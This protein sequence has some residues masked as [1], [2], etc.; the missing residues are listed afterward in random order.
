MYYAV[1]DIETRIDKS[2]VRQIYEDDDS[3]SEEEAYQKT[4][5]RL[6]E[7]NKG[8]TVFF[9]VPFHIPV[10]IVVGQI[11]DALELTNIFVL[12]ED[13]G[14]FSPMR[15]VSLFWDRMERFQGTLVSFN[16]RGFDLP[17][18]ELQA[19]KYGISAPRYFDTTSG[20]RY[21]FSDAGHFDLLD[22][23]TNYSAFFIK[24]GLNIL[25]KM[26]GLPGK[27]EI[28]GEDVQ[29]LWE[30]GDYKKIHNYCR[31]DVIQTYFLFLRVELLRGHIDQN[32]YEK[33]L[34]RTQAFMKELTG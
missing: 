12:G 25:S 28:K 11:N 17:V 32:R 19:L 5:H 24:G 22:F 15:L 8:K 13:E 9:P 34:E 27:G 30:K 7:E 29:G 14:D 33:I 23:L 31:K 2:L 20:C 1:L 6:L 10:S 4:W 3:I 16:G 21:R 26:I 18:L